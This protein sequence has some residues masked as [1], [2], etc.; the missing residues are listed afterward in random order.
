MTRFAIAIALSLTCYTSASL[1]DLKPD[2]LD[3]NAKKAGRNAALE[4]SIGVSGSCDPR[5]VAGDARDDLK[6]GVQDSADDARDR[7]GDATDHARNTVDG[8]R[9]LRKDKDKH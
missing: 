3:C 9:K 4:A 1:A 7:V 6:D 8:D 2:I 5:D